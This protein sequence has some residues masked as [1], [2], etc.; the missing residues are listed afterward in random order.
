MNVSPMILQDMTAH[1]GSMPDQSSRPRPSFNLL[2]APWIPVV[3]ADGT[4]AEVSTY[5]AVEHGDQ[6]V[7]LLDH[8][9]TMDAAILRFLLAVT[10]AANR[11]V[12]ANGDSVPEQYPVEQV[13]TY[14]REH[15]DS[16]DLFHP[17]RPFAQYADEIA[18]GPF[19]SPNRMVEGRAGE[20]KT[21]PSSHHAL[22]GAVLAPE[23]AT[24]YLLESLAWA[25]GGLSSIG[26]RPRIIAKSGKPGRTAKAG[27]LSTGAGRTT[28]IV[29]AATLHDTLLA[30]WHR[31]PV[32]GTPIWECDQATRPDGWLGRLVWPSYCYLLH[33]DADGNVDG[34]IITVGHDP[35]PGIGKLSEPS[36]IMRT[37]KAGELYASPHRDRARTL[38]DASCLVRS[39]DSLEGCQILREALIREEE[40]TGP[41]VVGITLIGRDGNFQDPSTNSERIDLAASTA[42]LGV[43][44]LETA[45]AMDTVADGIGKVAWGLPRRAMDQKGR[46]LEAQ[47]VQSSVRHHLIGA[48]IAYVSV[49]LTD[50]AAE[51][52]A[53][54]VLKDAARAVLDEHFE[55]A[56][57]HLSPLD[58]A[59]AQARYI[60]AKYE[61][62]PTNQQ[63]EPAHV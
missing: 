39:P 43:E 49:V 47:R 25:T 7:R 11:T 38:I 24:R 17:T 56:T 40:G 42:L 62:L 3:R 27:P 5:E 55:A 36:H 12:H 61:H 14:L 63:K 54:E 52:A 31:A 2:T 10:A 16:F 29:R 57:T 46:T 37:S 48:H 45:T 18:K 20:K 8:R 34:I 6:M 51:S 50:P 33:P 30:N 9:P 41:E 19:R 59:Q 26:T 60:K 53:R 1:T 58:Y 32:L 44:D 23:D 13:M 15:E 21:F 28:V 4:Y 22:D 35:E